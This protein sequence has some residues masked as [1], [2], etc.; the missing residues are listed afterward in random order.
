MS[1]F[2]RWYVKLMPLFSVRE[3]WLLFSYITYGWYDKILWKI[4]EI[5]KDYLG[6]TNKC[7]DVN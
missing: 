7:D 3:L 6:T 1:K 5:K 2:D 4:H